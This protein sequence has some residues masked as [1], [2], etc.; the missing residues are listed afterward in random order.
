MEWKDG[1]AL[2]YVKVMLEWARYAQLAP[3]LFVNR[4]TRLVEKRKKG[5]VTRLPLF[6]RLGKE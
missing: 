4:R 2:I 3:G 5:S 1:T 6:D